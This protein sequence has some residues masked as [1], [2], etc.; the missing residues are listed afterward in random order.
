MC[1]ANITALLI[2]RKQRHDAFCRGDLTRKDCIGLPL[3]RT[4]SDFS[5]L[6]PCSSTHLTAASNIL[7]M[8]FVPIS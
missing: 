7:Q 3:S 8:C 1:T 5:F 4:C 6:A 2:S